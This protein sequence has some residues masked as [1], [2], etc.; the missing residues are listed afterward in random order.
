MFVVSGNPRVDSGGRSLYPHQHVEIEAHCGLVDHTVTLSQGSPRFPHTDLHCRSLLFLGTKPSPWGTAP[1]TPT[2]SSPSSPRKPCRVFLFSLSSVVLLRSPSRSDTCTF[3]SM[4]GHKLLCVW[5]MS[6]PH[7]VP[8]SLCLKSAHSR[9][10]AKAPWRC[11]PIC[12]PAL[13]GLR[14]PRRRVATRPSVSW[15]SP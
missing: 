1:A 11:H 5:A 8:H 12:L 6:H 4:L 14:V 9:C 15:T 3:T 7:S 13:W 10:S 2:G